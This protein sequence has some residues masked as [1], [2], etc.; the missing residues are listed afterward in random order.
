VSRLCARKAGCTRKSDS[1]RQGFEHCAPAPERLG[2]CL[3]KRSRYGLLPPELSPLARGATRRAKL[4]RQGGL[5]RT[6][7]HRQLS[8]CR[9]PQRPEFA[10]QRAV[11][12]GKADALCGASGAKTEWR[13][14]GRRGRAQ[15]LARRRTPPVAQA[16]SHVGN[17]RFWRK[18]HSAYAGGTFR[19]TRFSI[20]WTPTELGRQRA[21]TA[22]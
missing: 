22:G 15:R 5:V 16:V 10:T 8:P 13:L 18:M 1:S 14:N 6:L 21:R 12:A 19:G 20:I 3:A 7:L 17:S 4:C 9:A 2:S 11:Q